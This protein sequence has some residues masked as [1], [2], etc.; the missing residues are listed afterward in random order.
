MPFCPSCGH[1]FAND[2]PIEIGRWRLFVDKAELDDVRLPLT[3]AESGIV[4]TLAKARGRTI[5]SA[6]IAD[7]ISTNANSNVVSVLV[8]RIRAQLG[9]DAPIETVR[10]NGYRWREEWAA[11]PP[12]R[13]D[14]RL[15]RDA[16]AIERFRLATLAIGR[17]I[18]EADIC[19]IFE[20]SVSDY[21]RLAQR[22]GQP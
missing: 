8:H 16:K 7:R 12:G 15:A 5:S 4:H 9:E 2:V 19:S 21:A 20:I 11:L 1:N 22:V 17:N 13:V 18:A 6:T 10:G 3:R 14:L